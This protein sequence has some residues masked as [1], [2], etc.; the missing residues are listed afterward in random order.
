MFELNATVHSVIIRLLTH[1]FLVL[2]AGVIY[3]DSHEKNTLGLKGRGAAKGMGSKAS[4]G[5]KPIRLY[6]LIAPMITSL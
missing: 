2:N 4:M 6:I 3:I 1:E 5:I